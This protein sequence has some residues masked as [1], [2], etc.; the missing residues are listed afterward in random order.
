M[1]EAVMYTRVSSREQEQE[2]Y[3]LEAQT[4][5]VREYAE[6]SGIR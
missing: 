6:N 5:I 3:S 2:G 4:R 1:T